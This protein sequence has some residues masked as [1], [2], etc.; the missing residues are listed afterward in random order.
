M[1]N[2]LLD[3]LIAH[4]LRGG[5]NTPKLRGQL[6]ST[7][8]NPT[9]T[10]SS[11]PPA[12]LSISAAAT[13]ASFVPFLNYVGAEV[14]SKVTPQ[15]VAWAQSTTELLGRIDPADRRDLIVQYKNYKSGLLFPPQ[16]ITGMFYSFEYEA[17]T[18][19]I[20]DRHPL[21]L[22]LNKLQDSVL[23]INFHYLPPKLRFALFESMM[24]LIAPLPVS[25]LSLI[26][27]TY[28]QLMKRRLIG[29][30]SIVKRYTFSRIRG[31]V[32]F[33][34]PIEWA[35]ALAYPSERFMGT[36]LQNVWAESRRHLLNR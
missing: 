24:P 16:I 10:E 29:R 35:M 8:P 17:A 27:L 28:A 20:Y 12:P 1:P 36:S 4:Y 33:I 5:K 22:V 21:I 7:P 9:T 30:F 15:T 11:G 34:S 18:T 32:V 13:G 14:T 3:T 31:P 26:R 23:G 19:T 25:Q 6:H 2:N